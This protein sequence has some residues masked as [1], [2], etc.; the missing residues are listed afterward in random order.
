[1]VSLARIGDLEIRLLEGLQMSSA[2]APLFWMELFDYK[3]QMSVDSCGCHKIKGAGTLFENLIA[4]AKHS[5]ASSPREG[6][7]P[8]S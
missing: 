3:A 6:N 5:N 8:Q 7:E 1:M 4:H 2:N